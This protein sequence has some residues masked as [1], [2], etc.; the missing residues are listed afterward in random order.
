MKAQ[1]MRALLLSLLVLTASRRATADDWIHWRG[2]EQTGVARGQHLPDKFDIKD[3]GKNGLVWKE[4]YGGRNTPLVLKGRIYIIGGYD[5][6][7]P[8]EGERVVC[9]DEA[10]GKTLWEQK[11]NVF[12]TD[13]VSSRLGWTT[14]TADPEHERIYAQSSAGTLFCFDRDGKIVWKHE[15][16]EEYGRVSGY[17]GRLVSPVFDSGLVIQGMLSASWGDFAKGGQRFVAFDGATGAVVWWSNMGLP[18]KATHM[19]SP[20]IATINGQRLAIAGGGDGYIHALNVRSGKVVWDYPLANGPI[21]PTPVVHGNLVYCSHGEPNIGGGPVGGVVCLDAAHMDTAHKGPTPR[22]K[23]VWEYHR[24]VRFGLSSL[25]LADGLLYIPDD[26]AQ[27]YC[28]DAKTGKLLWKENYG[29]TSRGAPLVCDGKLYVFDVLGQL[30]VMTLD[31]KKPPSDTRH[32]RFKSSIPGAQVETNGTPI[33]VNGRLYFLTRDDLYCIGAEKLTPGGPYAS[34]PAESPYDPKATPSSVRIFPA[35][36]LAKPGEAMNF[37]VDFMDADGRVLPKNEAAAAT[38]SL[39]LPGKTPTGGQPPALDGEI[40]AANHSAVLTLGKKPLQQ[41]F[42]EV[43][44]GGKLVATARVRVAALVGFKA[45]F[46]KPP[47]GAPP[48]GWVNAAGKYAVKMFQGKKVLAKLNT[49]PNPYLAKANTYITGPD[50]S[51]YTIACDVYG[52]VIREK[53]PDVGVVNSRYSLILDGK[54]DP[55]TG[56]STAHLATWEAMPRL[57][58]SVP[59]AWKKDTWYRMKLTVDPTGAKA[60]AKGKIWERDQPEP[61][62]WLLTLDDPNP[63]RNGAA[64]LYGYIPN[65]FKASEPG[66]E[67]YYDNLSILPNK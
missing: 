34:M 19:S 59:F 39:P 50:A 17:G 54:T 1:A 46:S 61:S 8:T 62:D 60:R 11:F 42:L 49:N 63:N 7:L 52:T 9:L 26:S 2:P 37:T 65:V 33:A 58:V 29:T 40:Q 57:R 36:V 4:P 31:G 21:N 53:L 45:D 3:V 67:I 38:W 48:S 30:A 20:V 6:G 47:L 56:K 14:L 64:A 10:T 27:L 25:C 23:K 18:A 41:G 35:D 28:F 51:N 22:P 16:T 55:A 12:L 44:C 5:A 43:N 24:S 32:Y 15:L 13:V 66:S